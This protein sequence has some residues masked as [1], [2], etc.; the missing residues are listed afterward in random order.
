MTSE[1]SSS[2]YQ[3]KYREQ[4]VFTG[5]SKKYPNL[6]LALDGLG[7]CH[8]QEHV[9]RPMGIDSW[10]WIQCISG[11][12][13][14]LVNGS[15]YVV[16]PGDGML[17]PPGCSHI[18]YCLQEPWFVN[19]LCCNGSLLHS[20]TEL[21]ELTVPG[22]YHLPQPQKI[23][24]YEDE[25]CGTYRKDSQRSAFEISQIL[26]RLLTDL[27][28]DIKITQTSQTL[29]QDEK[30]HQAVCYM[31]EHFHESIGLADIAAFVG[32]SKEYLCHTF[33]KSTNATLLEYLT[34]IRLAEAK[35]ALL[36][37]P[38]KTVGEISRM[39]GFDSPSYFCAVFKKHEHLTPGQFCQG[40]R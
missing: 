25:I 6:P 33:K 16:A 15:S 2:I 14:L 1:H 22:V 39:C 38:D 12:G 21:L 8:L 5:H 13:E 30:I 3:T 26:Y 9:D 40:R 18:Y 29:P 7:V 31:Q 4:I 23:L 11:T 36:K 19:F 27:S 10:Q 34:Q 37:F 17:L 20:L 24:D 35:M 28:M 32:L